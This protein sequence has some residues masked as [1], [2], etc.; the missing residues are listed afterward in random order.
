MGRA[1]VEHRAGRTTGTRADVVRR[2][3]RE[4]GMPGEAFAG[5]TADPCG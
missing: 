1:R 2:A 3:G 5:R 4:T